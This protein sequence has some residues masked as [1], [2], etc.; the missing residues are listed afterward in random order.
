LK[1]DIIINSTI[2]ET[3][4]G[5][6]ENDILVE[7]YVE[8]PDNERMVGSLYKGVIRRVIPGMSAAFINIGWVQDAFPVV[9]SAGVTDSHPLMRMPAELQPENR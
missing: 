1:E 5:L 3:R 6:L 9:K 8:R 7:L 2:S 4:I